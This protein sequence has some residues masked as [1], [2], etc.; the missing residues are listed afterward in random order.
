MYIVYW[1]SYLPRYNV[2][3]DCYDDTILFLIVGG[4]PQDGTRFPPSVMIAR[5]KKFFRQLGR[6]VLW[7]VGMSG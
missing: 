6:S 1:N 5:T 3:W 2:Y 7:L 4:G